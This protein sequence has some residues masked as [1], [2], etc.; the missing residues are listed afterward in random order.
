MIAVAHELESGGE[1][2]DQQD[3][4]IKKVRQD[5]FTLL[6]KSKTPEKPAITRKAPDLLTPNPLTQMPPWYWPLPDPEKRIEVLESFMPPNENIPGDREILLNKLC[7]SNSFP[8]EEKKRIAQSYGKF[9]V[10]QVKELSAIL[11]KENRKTMIIWNNHPGTRDDIFT[12]F[13]KNQ[14]TWGRIIGT[15]DDEANKVFLEYPYESRGAF[16]EWEKQPLY[17]LLLGREN[18]DVYKKEKRL[19]E[20]IDRTFQVAGEK[21]KID[22]SLK[23]L[24]IFSIDAVKRDLREQV[25]ER[26]VNESKNNVRVLVKIA[27]ACIKENNERRNRGIEILNRVVDRIESEEVMD[28]QVCE[29]AAE[30][31]LKPVEELIPRCE[32]VL[33]RAITLDPQ[34]AVPWNSL[35]ALLTQ[36]PG[37]YDEA[38]AAYKKSIE[39]NPK[40]PYPWTGLGM[41]YQKL[42]RVQEAREAY[43]N[44][45]EIEPDNLNFLHNDAELA[46]VE[47]DL[48]RTRERLN[49]ASKHLKSD[50]DNRNHAVLE[51]ALAGAADDRKKMSAIHENLKAI[52]NRMKTP[53]T[54]DY[55]DMEPFIKKL[56]PPAQ[57][58]LQAWIA[59]VKHQSHQDPDAA[60]KSYL[61]KSE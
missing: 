50:E 60:Y 16:P 34:Y 4:L 8:K 51:L 39:L 19:W 17:W 9:T 1:D 45:I 7:W 18:F 37:R 36:H 24:E 5:T 54:W 10:G 32:M 47:N 58:L 57:N 21:G 22:V 20:S 2:S 12:I 40:Y 11:D 27:E 53:S 38:E 56:T 28:A 61:N 23:I 31:I 52:H 13:F 25:E 33:R 42:G 6:K 3:Q 48:E 55:N 15:S 30:I 59:A 44:A 43:H 35:G 41:L 49:R 46:L 29:Y 26:V 14:R